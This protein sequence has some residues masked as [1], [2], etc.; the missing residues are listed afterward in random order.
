[1]YSSRSVGSSRRRLAARFASLAKQL[2]CAVAMLLGEL[3]E[4]EMSVLSWENH[5]KTIGTIGK[6]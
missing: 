2:R 1:M 5:R 4:L 6:W 3:G